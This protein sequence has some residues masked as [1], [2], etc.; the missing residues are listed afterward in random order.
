MGTKRRLAPE[1]MK[2]AA[3][4]ADGPVLDLFSGMCSVGAIVSPKR[5]VWVNDLQIFSHEVGKALF[6]SGS[7]PPCRANVFIHLTENFSSHLRLLTSM[8][9]EDIQKEEEANRKDDYIASLRLMDD[10]SNIEANNLGNKLKAINHCLFISTYSASYFGILQCAEID[11]AVFSIDSALT[12]GHLNLNDARWI[13]IA[14]AIAINKVSASTGHFAQHLTPSYANKK[15][16]HAQ[17]RRSV[18]QEWLTAIEHMEDLSFVDGD[19]SIKNRAFNSDAIDLLDLLC[20]ENSAPAVIYADPPYTDDQYSRFYHIYETLF[21]YDYPLISGKGRYRKE[22]VTSDFSL[23]SKVSHSIEE[24]ISKTST[25]GSDLIISYPGNGLL[26]DS[27]EVIPELLSK[28]FTGKV[29]S[30]CVPYIHSS[31]GGG[32]ARVN[33]TEVTEYLYRGTHYV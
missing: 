20:E 2:L 4:R 16:F 30:T 27:H 7:A 8:A 13:R 9:S 14:L 29:T 11:A 10:F 23:K 1:V 12:G 31:M 15:R 22:R 5:P 25:L 33:K 26:P 32:T 17:R 24:L 3:M 18:F 21:L 6:C 19:N 28:Y